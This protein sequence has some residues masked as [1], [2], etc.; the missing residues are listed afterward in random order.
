[1]E[2]TTRPGAL[3]LSEVTRVRG[4]GETAHV[5]VRA[6]PGHEPYHRVRDPR[7]SRRHLDR[8]HVQPDFGGPRADGPPRRVPRAV[9]DLPLLT[10]HS[11]NRS[12]GILRPGW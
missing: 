4:R 5:R 1:M 10:Q 8:L 9:C 6:N 3:R 7:D 11:I 2:G 12:R